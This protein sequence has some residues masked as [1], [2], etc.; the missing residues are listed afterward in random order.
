MSIRLSCPSCNTAFDLSAVPADRRATCPRCADVFPIRGEVAEHVAGEP[1]TQPTHAKYDPPPAKRGLSLPWAVAIALMLGLVGFAAGLAVYYTRGPKT[2]AE[3]PPQAP[4]SITA[5]PPAQ[6]VGLGYLP[7]ECNVVFAVQSGPLLAHAAHTKQDPH[8]LIGTA[9]VP[10]AVLGALESTGLTLQQIDHFAGGLFLPSGPEEL[11]AAFAV[12]LKQP[13][14]DEAEFLKKLQAKPLPDKKARYTVTL[15]KL[16]I[17]EVAR[18]APTVWVFG[19]SAGDF[20]AVEK[21]GFGPSGTQFRGNES[22]GIRRMLGAVPPGA[23]MWLIAD[24]EREWTEK[25]AV[26]GLLQVRPE[27]KK[28]VPALKGGRGGVFALTFGEQARMRL[29]VRTAETATAE[30]VRTYFQARAAEV[31]SATAGGG[32]VF[33]LFDAPF[34]PKL[35]ERF[36]A[37]AAK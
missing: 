29:F 6:L 4:A 22:E 27:A 23:A 8:E 2:T 34:D 14:P 35:I 37:D 7:T 13:L 36:L 20:A 9:S 10:G 18:V 15:G 17:G 26:S 3:P 31:E 12:V 11:R 1:P 32:G 24:D 21:G 25:P 28:L 16:P 30:R 19:L 5:T 33:A